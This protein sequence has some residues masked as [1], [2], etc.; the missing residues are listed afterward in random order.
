MKVLIT[1]ANGFVA[2]N[3]SVHLSERQGIEML[4][5]TR[6]NSIGELSFLIRDVDF[7][8]LIFHLGNKILFHLS[9]YPNPLKH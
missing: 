3:L 4:T 6:D 1:G 5:F 9:T 8:F 2:K 7:I